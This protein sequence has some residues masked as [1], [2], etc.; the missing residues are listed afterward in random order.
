MN[1]AGII[2]RLEALED[3]RKAAQPKP[4]VC[5]TRLWDDGKLL[6]EQTW[7]DGKEVRGYTGPV[8]FMIN[9]IIVTPII[10]LGWNDN[11]PIST[12]KN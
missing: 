9:R 2:K 8:D 5:V 12:V 3:K 1:M 11:D 10:P 6:R 7:K 4:W